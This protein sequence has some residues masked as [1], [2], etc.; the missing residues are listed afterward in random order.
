MGLLATRV[1]P[2][3]AALAT[4]QPQQRQQDQR[5]NDYRDD[6]S[7]IHTSLLPSGVLGR[8][9]RQWGPVRLLRGLLLFLLLVL[10]QL[11]LQHLP[12]RVAGQLVDELELAR[13]LEVREVLLD[14]ALQL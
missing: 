3:L 14:V 9:T 5:T 1:E 8:G 4:Q 13:H 12:G 6:D 11:P 7:G 10:D 2:A